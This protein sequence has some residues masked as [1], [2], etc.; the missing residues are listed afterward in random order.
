MP[1]LSEQMT[2]VQPRVSTEGKLLTMAF[3]L[4][5]RRVPSARH[6]VMT[7]GRPEGLRG[8]GRSLI[9]ATLFVYLLLALKPLAAVSQSVLSFVTDKKFMY[10]SLSTVWPSLNHRLIYSKHSEPAL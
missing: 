9:M 6:V 5:I 1:V 2:E 4:A 10:S 7:A 8:S 3:F